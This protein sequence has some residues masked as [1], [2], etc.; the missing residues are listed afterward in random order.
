MQQSSVRP[1]PPQ[2]RAPPPPPPFWVGSLCRGL[3]GE[4]EEEEEGRPLLH[5]H[6][7]VGV[8]NE[9]TKIQA[10]K[11]EFPTILLLLVVQKGQEKEIS[12]LFPLP[13]IWKSAKLQ[14][15]KLKS[16]PTL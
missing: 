8:Y 2:M 9:R 7:Y 12:A 4:E 15:R 16:F 11:L 14:E 1:P 3:K 10:K 13:R 6:G 5:C